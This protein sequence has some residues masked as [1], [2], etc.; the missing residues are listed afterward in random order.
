[1]VRMSAPHLHPY[2]VQERLRVDAAVAGAPEQTVCLVERAER[3]GLDRVLLTET[4]HDPF[5]LLA[6]S[7]ARTER[8]ELGTGIAVATARTPMTLAYSAWTLQALSRGRA[9]IGLGSQVKA[10]VERRFAMPWTHPAERMDEFARATRAIWAS[11]QHGEPLD[12]RGRFYQHTLMGPPFDP[13]RLEHGP[14]PLLIAAVGPMMAATAGRTGDG[15]LLHP[16]STPAH[17]R[18]QVLPAV[19]TARQR[20]E[21]AGDPWTHR[22][23]EVCGAAFAAIGH[24][25]QEIDEAVRSVRERIAFYASTPG[26][27]SV[28]DSLGARDL[29][30]EARRLARDGRWSEMGQLVDDDV[31]A[32]FAVVGT[33]DQVARAIDARYRGLVDRIS[34][35]SGRRADPGAV[36]EALAATRRLQHP[37]EP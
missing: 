6:V 18:E 35:V 25:E 10:H 14:P 28:L 11:W 15:V 7:S 31:L 22:R 26:Y 2:L 3:L 20:A 9:V 19:L 8:I 37:A 13:G 5:Q 1:M 36:L 32:A 29:H 27:E 17:L 34:I 24:T 12:F 4:A 16:F 30:T 33:P 23:F 21:E